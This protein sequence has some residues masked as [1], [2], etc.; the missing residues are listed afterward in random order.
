VSKSEEKRLSAKDIEGITQFIR[1]EGYAWIDGQ[2]FH[3]IRAI[4]VPIFDSQGELQA[5]IS[6]VSNQASLVQFPNPVLDD[7]MATGQRI[8]HR[9]GWSN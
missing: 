4:A 3:S 6:L 5:T 2:L 9:L 7:L 8:S 1:R